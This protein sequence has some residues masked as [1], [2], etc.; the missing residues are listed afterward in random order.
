MD[1]YA[2]DR[3]VTANSIQYLNLIHKLGLSGYR[4]ALINNIEFVSSKVSRL[5]PVSVFWFT[6]LLG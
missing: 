3:R 4:V 1:G 6:S 5:L 2:F